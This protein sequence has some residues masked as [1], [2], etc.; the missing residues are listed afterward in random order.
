M[1]DVNE[2]RPDEVEPAETPTAPDR[3][4]GSEEPASDQEEQ[5]TELFGAHAELESLSDLMEA[6]AIAATKLRDMQRLGIGEYH[7]T[8][9]EFPSSSEEDDTIIILC[10]GYDDALQVNANINTHELTILAR[11]SAHVAA[12]VRLMPYK[13]KMRILDMPESE[14]EAED[15]ASEAEPAQ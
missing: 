1:S 13:A 8:I 3:P 5:E 4:D 2:K 14:V 6:W 10:A 15:S 7:E 12:I 9:E 11:D